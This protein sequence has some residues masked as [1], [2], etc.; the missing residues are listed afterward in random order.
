MQHGPRTVVAE[1]RRA[2]L[3]QELAARL[4]VASLVLAFSALVPGEHETDSV[5]RLTAVIAIGLNLPYLLAF[6]T[7][8]AL[9]AQAYLRSLVDVALI[10]AG[11][12]GAGG[13]GAA[14][15]IAIYAIVPVYSA[16]V[17]SSLACVLAVVFATVAYLAVAL[18]QVDG[19]LPFLRPPLQGAW[20]IA[21]FNLLV[22]NIVGWLAALVAKAYRRSQGRLTS[23]YAELERAHDQ[24]L[25]LNTQLQLTAR[26]YVLSEVV[27]GITYEVRDA[28]QSAFGHLW[29]A[30]RGGPPLPAE[31]LDH[32]GR[33]EEAC[34]SAMRIMSTA[35]DN[36]RHPEP[37]PEPIAIADVAR[38]VVDLKAVEVRRERITLSVD[39]PAGLPLVLGTSFQLQQVLLNLVVN[40]QE[41]LR[42]RPGRREIT[43]VG[44]AD[45]DHV[46]AEVRDTGPGI[47][48]GVLSRVFEPFYTTKPEATGLGL[49]ISAGIA[50]RLHGTLTAENG[51][52]GGAIFRLTL[53]AAV[54]SEPASTGSAAAS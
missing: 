50:E 4:A 40:A 11:L 19:V 52:A 10:T 17:F 36:A 29:L 26:R 48:P 15:Y 45:A 22:L 13:L 46:I 41:E 16:I 27:A 3:R 9:R 1:R 23:L 18:L 7:G 14:Q 51:R 37:A 54:P 5:V 33:V 31:A 53:P 47:P 43:I 12:Y 20:A 42:S 35:L 34:E 2:R 8:Y 25:Q 28:L 21:G 39:V 38:R 32:L 44:R 6:Q 49:A 30:R 24:S